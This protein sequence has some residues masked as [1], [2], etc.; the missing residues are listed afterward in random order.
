VSTYTIG[1]VAE[2]TGFSAS[3]LRYYDGIGLV[4]PATWT[5]AGYRLYHDQ[6]LARL[7]FIAR[8]KQLGC[9]LDEITDLVSIWDG[10]R[11]G[12]VQRRFHALVIDKIRDAES[13]ITEL[14]A[15]SQQLQAAAAQLSGEPV[16][17]HCGVDCA[18]VTDTATTSSTVVPIALTSKTTEAPI[19]CTLDA[20]A[21]PERLADWRAILAH[22]LARTTCSDG[23]LRVELDGAVDVG[24]LARIVAAEQQCCAFF[25]FAIT[26]DHRGVALQV[27]APAGAEE[28]VTSLF[29]Q[30]A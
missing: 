20:G 5:E 21:M 9:S 22:A 12:P 25:S 30:P 11:C 15:F 16:D 1:Q 18:C 8:A 13:Q 3:A 6:T 28:I 26:V 2:R 10:E 14:D 4:A 7:A 19:A 24:E 27:G 17:G 23:A 29:G